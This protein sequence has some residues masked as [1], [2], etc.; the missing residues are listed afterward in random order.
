MDFERRQ[1]QNKNLWH[2]THHRPSASLAIV[3]DRVSLAARASSSS[4]R[5]MRR[6]RVI[7]TRSTVSSSAAGSIVTSERI[8]RRI[9]AWRGSKAGNRFAYCSL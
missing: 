8:N 3:A 7:L 1:E 6:G 2:R 4:R 5:R 9:P